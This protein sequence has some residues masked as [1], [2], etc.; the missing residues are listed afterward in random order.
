MERRELEKRT[1]EVFHEIHVAQGDDPYIFH[2]VA[3]LLSTSY[4]KVDDDFLFDKVCLDAGCGSNAHT[5]YSLV[6]MGAKKVYAFDLDETVLESAPKYLHGFEGKYELSVGNI[7]NMDFKDEFFDFTYCGGVLHHTLDVFE[8]LKEL[9]RVTKVGGMLYL[10][11]YGKGGLAREITDFLRQKY[12]HDQEFKS[13]VDNVNAED[14]VEVFHWIF[15]VMDDHGDALGKTIPVSLLEELFDKDLV[16]TIK[17][18]ITAPVYQQISEGEL[19]GWLRD[20]RFSNIER[21]TRYPTYKN[22]RRFLSPFYERHEHKFSKFL[23]GDGN[24]QLKAIKVG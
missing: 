7:L 10:E 23:Y 9:A 8:G 1:R 17:D 3:S 14:F 24:I 15:S 6:R 16:L 19:V 11:V 18:R 22:I 13:L 21:L 20:N 12:V 5:T 2:R 4:L